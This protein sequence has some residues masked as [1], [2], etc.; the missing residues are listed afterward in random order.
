MPG[1]SERINL[2][3]SKWRSKP[4]V[5]VLDLSASRAHFIEDGIMDEH[6]WGLLPEGKRILF[7]LKEVNDP[8]CDN[9]WALQDHLSKDAKS[10][11]WYRVAEW[12]KGIIETQAG[13]PDVLFTCF[14]QG[15]GTHEWLKRIAV[16]NLKK[17][18]GGSSS[19]MDVVNSFAQADAAEIR[20][21]IGI[22]DPDIIILGGTGSAFYKVCGLDDNM[23][24]I[25][26]RLH[27]YAYYNL[28]GRDRLVIDYYHPSIRVS[29][30]L[31]YYGIMGV[32]R[33]ALNSRN[34]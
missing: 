3:F 15:T 13:K 8:N 34:E 7:V 12:A 10:T 1:Y 26:D 18:P 29:K 31:S 9:D 33:H 27:Q 2:L 25:K 23:A 20:E 6:E 32:Y 14:P 22:I 4:D 30:L 24:I 19:N 5:D 11:M 16:L 17:T 28:L 21:E